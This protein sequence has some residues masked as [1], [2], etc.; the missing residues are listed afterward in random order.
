MAVAAQIIA[1]GQVPD[2]KGTLFTC[3]TGATAYVKFMPIVNTNAAQ[4]TVVI[5]VKKS[6][7]TSRIIARA[8]LDQWE[9]F[10]PWEAGEVVMLTS[11][12]EIEGVTTTA[13][14][15]D[16]VIFGGVES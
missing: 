6:G 12:D 3:P 14:A 13:A 4:Q 10:T 11:G 1:E 7:E 9:R 5:Y 2:S 8:V 15:V 16:Y